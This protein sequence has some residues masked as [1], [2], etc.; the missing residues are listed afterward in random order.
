MFWAGDG[1][2]R[3]PHGGTTEISHKETPYN[4]RSQINNNLILTT[5][6]LHST[7]YIPDKTVKD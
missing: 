6:P 7:N 1:R 4:L 2:T 3:A 5:V